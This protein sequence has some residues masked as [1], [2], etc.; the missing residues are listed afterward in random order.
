VK[1]TITFA[2]IDFILDLAEN[3]PDIVAEADDWD[4]PVTSEEF[5]DSVANQIMNQPKKVIPY[6]KEMLAED[7]KLVSWAG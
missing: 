7:K 5:F 1:N 3:D 6:T 2:I 4:D